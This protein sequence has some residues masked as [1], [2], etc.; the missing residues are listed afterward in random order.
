MKCRF[1]GYDLKVLGQN[2][3]SPL[4]EKCL[5]NPKGNHVAMPN[6]TLCVY[7]GRATSTNSGK[8]RTD[9]GFSCPASPTGM[10]ALM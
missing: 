4:G 3:R 1:C 9:F 6:G 5:G 8:L 7:C 10:H 2:L